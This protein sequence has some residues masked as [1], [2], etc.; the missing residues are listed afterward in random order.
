MRTWLKDKWT[1]FKA[2]FVGV[3]V[4]IGIAVA[5]MAV[6]AAV[7]FSWTLPTQNTDGSALSVTQIVE[8]RLYCDIDP[9]AFTPQTSTSPASH[10][11]DAVIPGPGTSAVHDLSFGRHA[12]FA[13][14]LAEYT[15]GAGTTARVESAP[16]GVV[17]KIVAPPQ[18]SPPAFN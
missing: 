16:S 13:T 10:A 5:P 11:A 14:V 2:W 8:T 18:P 17:E 9:V 6:T 12:C 15:D 1:R 3:L 7:S 4:A